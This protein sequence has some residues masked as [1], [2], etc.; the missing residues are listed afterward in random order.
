MHTT[1]FAPLRAI[2]ASAQRARIFTAL[3]TALLL[4]AP[5]Q[6]PGQVR[7]HYD[8][9]GRLIQV[10]APDGR[11]A[12]YTYDALGNILSIQN[13][14]AT[15]LSISEFTPNSGQVGT[16]VTIYGSGFS[17]TPSDNTVNFNGTA[18][19]VAAATATSL[20][21]AVP[22]NASSGPITVTNTNGTTTSSSAFSV[23]GSLAPTI[24]SFTPDVGPQRGVISVTGT[25]FQTAPQ[26]NKLTVG[27]LPVNVIKDATSPTDTLLKT[28][29][30]T[31]SG[32]VSI[33]TLHGTATSTADYYAVP[34]YV[35]GIVEFKARTAVDGPPVNVATTTPGKRFVL[36]FDGEPGQGLRLVAS[37]G[38]FASTITFTVHT[39]TGSTPES[40]TI[41]NA[42]VVSF[43][44]RL[45]E[46]GTYTIAFYPK[47]DDKGTISLSLISDLTGVLTVDG[48]TPMSLSGG[49]LAR[50]SFPA[51][52]GKGYGLALSGLTTTP[53]GRGLYVTL[54]SPDGTSLLRTFTNVAS[55]VSY[56]TSYFPTSGNY[57]IDFEQPTADYAASFNAVLSRDKA[58][59]IVA[60][61]PSPTT[62]TI[63]REGQN[64]RLAFNGAAGQAFSVVLTGQ[65]MDDG[66]PTTSSRTYIYINRPSDGL[67][68]NSVDVFAG[69]TGASVG[70]VL[71]QSGTYNIV[72]DPRMEKGSIDVQLKSYV[73][74][75]WT[76]DG[77]TS[78]VELASG[79]WGRF[80]FNAAAGQGYALGITEL[81]FSQAGRSMYARLRSADGAYLVS[82]YFGASGVCNFASSL[83]TS[84]GTYY[85]DFDPVS[86]GVFSTSFKAS[87]SPN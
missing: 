70:E 30:S 59:T 13:V 12:Q 39:P 11:S 28:P 65:A 57:L 8:E 24:S 76:A 49:Q 4:L 80:A 50:Y 14:A 52:A 34:S 68:V 82:C 45:T 77:I 19:V 41:G 74:G 75:T 62:V 18:A 71:E 5:L 38:T 48:S 16:T 78:P 85:I 66:D 83:F 20:T 36:I 64:G 47:S 51:E 79:R 7:Y 9:A 37:S 15:S 40:L 10:V 44:K 67:T 22:S 2:K 21:V 6:A 42:G 58:G 29:T 60:D 23:V 32:K 63:D 25:G 69:S 1:C 73:T 26:D 56:N 54:R 27:G 17:T 87:L 84:A 61:A 33:A 72:I 81:A 86:Y 46:A 53:S 3:L 31:S 43:T 35:D 55:D